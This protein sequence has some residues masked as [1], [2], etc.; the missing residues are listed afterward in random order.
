MMGHIVKAS[1]ISYTHHKRQG[2]LYSLSEYLATGSA[3]KSCSAASASQGSQVLVQ[4][5]WGQVLAMRQDP[6]QLTAFGSSKA[7]SEK[8]GKQLCGLSC[9]LTHSEL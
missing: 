2:V 3:R 5:A 1:G 4:L 9:C 7:L 8:D 6:S